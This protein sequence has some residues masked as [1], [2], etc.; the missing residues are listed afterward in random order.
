MPTDAAQTDPSPK[1]V[2]LYSHDTLG[3]GHLRRNLMLAERLKALEPAPEVLLVAGTCE[4]G[5]FA[6]LLEMVPDRVC[7]I[8]TERAE[9]CLILSLGS[10]PDAHGQLLIYHDMFGLYPKFTPKMARVYADAG[11]AILGGLKQYVEDVTTK[12][13]PQRENWFRMRNSAY[14]ELTQE[15]D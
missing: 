11:Q 8:I 7:K 4:A 14:E 2:I 10:G 5:A 1:R 15:L 6:I 9:D 3:F 13:F 12:D